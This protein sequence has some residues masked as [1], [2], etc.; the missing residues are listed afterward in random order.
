MPPKRWYLRTIPHGA[1]V[2]NILQEN[3]T[4]SSCSVVSNPTSY[5]KFSGSVLLTDILRGSLR[6]SEKM[7]GN[8]FKHATTIFFHILS[9]SRL[10]NL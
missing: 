2:S 3:R 6:V 1:S 10:G 9:K 4:R 8:T 7:F 5:S